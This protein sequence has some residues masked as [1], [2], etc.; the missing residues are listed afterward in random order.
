MIF[1][2]HDD[3]SRHARAHLGIVPFECSE[4]TYKAN[5]IQDLTNHMMEKDHMTEKISGMKT[6]QTFADKVKDKVKNSR[7]TRKK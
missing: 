2:N 5:K 7:N 1:E 4:C 3:Y 6:R